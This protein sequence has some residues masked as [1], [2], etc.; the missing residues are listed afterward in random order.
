MKPQQTENNKN[1]KG[2]KQTTRNLYKMILRGD[3]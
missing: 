2:L 1:K 3:G